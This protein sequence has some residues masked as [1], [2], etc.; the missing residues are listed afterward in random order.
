MTL[1]TS[2]TLRLIFLGTLGVLTMFAL[3]TRAFGQSADA[4]PAPKPNALTPPKRV[5]PVPAEY[6]AGDGFDEAAVDAGRRFVFEPARRGDT[7]IPSRIRYQYAFKLPPP[8]S[9]PAPT[10][11]VLEGKV[12]LRGGDDRVVGADVTVT[13]EDG[14]VV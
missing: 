11:G 8:P 4:A 1:R 12:L 10:T 7:P 14:K 6:P 9:P 5:P 2:M 3:A 13:S